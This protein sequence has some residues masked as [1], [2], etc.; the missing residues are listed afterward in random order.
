MKYEEIQALEE[1]KAQARAAL[2]AR[3]EMLAEQERADEER[4]ERARVEQWDA[5]KAHLVEIVPAALWPLLRFDHDAHVPRNHC[6]VSFCV[7]D[8]EIMQLGVR[9]GA[10]MKTEFAE[11]RVPDV[12]LYDGDEGWHA[13]FVFNPRGYNSNVKKNTEGGRYNDACYW[14][15]ATAHAFEQLDILQGF[16]VEAERHNVEQAV[17][18]F[19]RAVLV[20]TEPEERAFRLIET[21]SC[22][23]LQYNVEKAL[24][25]GWILHGPT[26]VVMQQDP[27]N[28]ACLIPVYYQAL[29]RNQEAF[30]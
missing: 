24:A 3:R 8:A 6:S 5:F 28:N 7:Y 9:V 20:D 12:R 2:A 30:Q 25:S 22:S 11:L 26:Q 29:V 4:L 13:G 15:V 17:A 19:A 1:Y 18:Q 21:E 14:D 16:E 10:N 27:E 23:D